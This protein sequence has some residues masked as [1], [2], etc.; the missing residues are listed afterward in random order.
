MNLPIS[1]VKNLNAKTG[2][3][4]IGGQLGAIEY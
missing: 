4:P 2:E 3:H 1:D